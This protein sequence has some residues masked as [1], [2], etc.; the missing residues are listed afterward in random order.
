MNLADYIE[1][2]SYLYAVSKERATL[3]NPVVVL[4]FDKFPY[5]Y[6]VAFNTVFFELYINK[7]YQVK[8]E[9]T[10]EENN[11]LHSTISNFSLEEGF[12]PRLPKQGRGS[13]QVEI[14]TPLIINNEGRCKVTLTLMDRDNQVLDSKVTYIDFEMDGEV[15]GTD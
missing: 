1:K 10:D 14:K 5:S 13:T 12:L 4:T 3:G 6:D 2:I 9:L 8:I 11:D 7:T 15:S